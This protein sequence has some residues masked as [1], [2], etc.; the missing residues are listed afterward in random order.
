MLLVGGGAV[1]VLIVLMVSKKFSGLKMTLGACFSR[2]LLIPRN[3][4]Q[5]KSLGSGKIL[6]GVWV[7]G[8]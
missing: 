5:R 3:H 1:V 4:G 6:D 7:V 8:R 2:I